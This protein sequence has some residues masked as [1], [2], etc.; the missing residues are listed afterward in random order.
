MAHLLWLDSQLLT[1]EDE[2]RRQQIYRDIMLGCGWKQGKVLAEIPPWSEIKRIIA[3]RAPGERQTIIQGALLERI[4]KE[5]KSLKLGG[6]SGIQYEEEALSTPL[7]DFLLTEDPPTPLPDLRY[8]KA[9]DFFLSPPN[10]SS[11]ALLS[12]PVL[13]KRLDL[14]L[15][16][17]T[18][19]DLVDQFLPLNG[20]NPFFSHFIDKFGIG[21]PYRKFLNGTI[22]LRLHI[23]ERPNDR[24][25]V[26]L[27][28]L[29]TVDTLLTRMNSSRLKE[30]SKVTVAVWD[31][32]AQHDRLIIGDIGGLHLG[33]GLNSGRHRFEVTS[34]ENP[35][36]S[37]R[38]LD[39]DIMAAKGFIRFLQ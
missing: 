12:D 4:I 20:S 21:G 13:L 5:K 23:S 11:K 26:T 6:I 35:K 16:G 15:I 32:G 33:R 17:S 3:S 30:F 34:S 38:I 29:E 9:D 7:I 14:L 18:R 36:E 37:R 1:H 27:A 25:P 10:F 39:Q 8:R 31:L 24:V 22:E 2:T 19:I 28:H